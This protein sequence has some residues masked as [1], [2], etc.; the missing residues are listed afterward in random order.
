MK[1]FELTYL[2]HGQQIPEGW[3]LVA[4]FD[5]CHHGRYSQGII[6]KIEKAEGRCPFCGNPL[7]EDWNGAH[8]ACQTCRQVTQ[9]CCCGAGNGETG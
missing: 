9:A 3:E 2:R 1:E 5:N 7:V 6:K 4:D 8:Y